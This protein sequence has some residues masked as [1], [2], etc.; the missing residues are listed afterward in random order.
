M[1]VQSDMDLLVDKQDHNSFFIV[2]VK[3]Y[4]GLANE[5]S[6]KKQYTV[7]TIKG[8]SGILILNIWNKRH[9]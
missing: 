1:Y 6:L 8:I 3:A 2:E 5:R 4:E 7:S 9:S